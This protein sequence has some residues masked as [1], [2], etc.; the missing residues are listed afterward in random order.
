MATVDAGSISSEVRIRL[1]KLQQDISKVETSYDNLNKQIKTSSKQT[2]D[3]VEKGF[4][5]INLA[6][7]AAFAGITVALKSAIG[8][9][10]DFE[11]SIANVGAV[12]NATEEDF[13]ILEEAARSAGE[14]TRFSASQAADALFFLSSAGLDATQSVKAL[15][16][17]L[18]L[19]GATGS[20]L[21]R[22]AETVTA[23]LSQFDIAASDSAR[24]SNVFAA[25]NSNSQATLEKLGNALRQVG[26]VA[27][28]LGIS[29]EETTGAL[30]ILFNAGFQGETAGRALKSALADLATETGPTIEKLNKLGI[31]FE[32]VNP[33]VVGVEGAIRTLQEAG[34][35]TSQVIDVFGKVAGPQLSVLIK[36]GADSIKDY[37]DAVTGTNEAARQ[38]AVQNDTLKGSTDQFNSALESVIISFVK[39]LSPAIRAVVDVGTGFLKL[40]NSFPGPIKTFIGLLAAGAAGLGLVTTALGAFGIS[41]SVALGPVTA[42]IAG[43]SAL[44]A[45]ITAIGGAIKEA[46]IKDLEEEFGDL[47]RELDVTAEKAEAVAR[48]LNLGMGQTFERTKEQVKELADALGLTEEQVLNIGLA[49]DDLTDQ[50]KEQLQT[51]KDQNE[52]LRIQQEEQTRIAEEQVRQQIILDKLAAGI[53]LTARELEL[54]GLEASKYGEKLRENL[55]T[56][57]DEARLAREQKKE[58]ERIAAIINARKEAEKNVADEVDKTNRLLA[59]GAIDQLE[60]NNRIIKA[61]EKL[62]DVLADIGYNGL[63]GELG[64]KALIDAI[65]LVNKLTEANKNLVE[66]T[67]DA[68]EE[69]TDKT[70]E[71]TKTIFE[72]FKDQIDSFSDL[73]IEST[74]ASLEEWI[75]YFSFIKTLA[76]DAFTSLA[77]LTQLGL[78]KQIDASEKA[79]NEQIKNIDEATQRE[80]ERLGLVE[81]TRVQQLQDRLKAAISAGN[82]ETA[83]ELRQEI[84]R[85]QI[86]DSAE[87]RKSAIIEKAEKEKARIEYKSAL[88]SWT[89]NAAKVAA[90]N[91]VAIAKAI[92]SAPPPLNIP[93]ITGQT[94][95]TGAQAANVALTKPN[96]P[97]FQTGGIV[98][99]TPGG[100][101]AKVAENGSD[102][103]LFNAGSSGLPFLKQFAS[104]IADELR[105]KGNVVKIEVNSI[106]DGEI[107]AKNVASYY[108]NGKVKLNR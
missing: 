24:V 20:D 51:I 80:L 84:K 33:A 102:E 94:L 71:E 74:G 49:N 19:A 96:P 103:L 101:I 97:S 77:E 40:L 12:A 25:A 46:R 29:L 7:V 88:I 2:G 1:D 47:S 15:D 58:Q 55:K 17:V 69:S 28:G 75:N 79:K 104:V 14:T 41:L 22:T 48:A 60:A 23:T 62:I 43:V 26:P 52:E 45:G 10:S 56:A 82:T 65:A 89:L 81:K 66:E 87:K 106:L 30:Q 50:F 16:G 85:T 67:D 9:F 99:A 32:S 18:L 34:L 36:E 27:A 35:D 59:I 78:Q 53:A 68:V 93:A 44:V 13:A 39:E 5:Q 95:L 72:E 107:V 42:V 61:N 57:E 105:G 4:Q 70:I 37:T 86:I 64:D 6:G 90:E 92:A 91:V 98:K 108:N 8:T 83:N 76:F 21:A 54:S 38:Y 11:Q 31:S 73:V 3:Q 63:R 100:T